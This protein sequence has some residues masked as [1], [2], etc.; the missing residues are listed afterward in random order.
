MDVEGPGYVHMVDTSK[1]IAA[2]SMVDEACGHSCEDIP[3]T[4]VIACGEARRCKRS[5]AGALKEAWAAA[6]G[7]WQEG[8]GSS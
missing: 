2:M 4:V 6:H 1:G 3:C 5:L 7:A 8:G